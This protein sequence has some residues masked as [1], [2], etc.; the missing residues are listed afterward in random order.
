MKTLKNALS[1]LGIPFT[2]ATLETF[3]EYMKAV[4]LWNEHMNLTA[5]TDPDMFAIKHFADSVFCACWP[6]T[7]AAREVVDVGTGAGFPGIPLAILLPEHRFTLIDSLGKRVRVIEDILRRLDLTNVR[8][9]H[10][11]AE[12][13]ARDVSFRG[14][15][16]LCVSRAVARLPVL[17]EYCLPFLSVGGFMFAYKGDDVGNEVAAAQNAFSL[18][19]GGLCD[20]R[21]VSLK[22]HGLRHS[23]VVVKKTG[24]TPLKYPRR[25]GAPERKPL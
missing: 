23:I 17:A 9:V 1:A 16:D 25:A 8:A 2:E 19:G 13:I 5:I 21:A 15:F 24:E 22:A 18:L 11:R 12:D 10:G 4:L 7:L 20:V 6:E 14:V 3:R